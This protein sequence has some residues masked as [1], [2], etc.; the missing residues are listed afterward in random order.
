VEEARQ[1]RIR[2]VQLDTRRGIRFRR[3]G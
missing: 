3:H 2:P 1:I